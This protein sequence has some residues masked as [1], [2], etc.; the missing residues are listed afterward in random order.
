MNGPSTDNRIAVMKAITSK[1]LAC[2]GL[3]FTLYS[4]AVLAVD[5]DA[6]LIRP[7]VLASMQPG[8]MDQSIADTRTALT[9]HKFSIAGEYSPYKGVHI[10]AVTSDELKSTAA[11]STH[12]GYGAAIR[13]SITQDGAN[14]Q[15][16]YTNPYYMANVYRM[17]SDLEGVTAALKSALG[18]I[19]DFGSEDGWRPKSLRDYHYM[20]FMPY[21]DDHNTLATHSD[22]KTALAAVE[23]GLKAGK[24]GTSKVY[25]IDIPGK[26]ESVFGVALSEG[27]SGDAHIMKI[28]DIANPKHTPHLP[29]ELLVSGNTVYALHGK[30]RIAIDFPDLTMDTFMKISDS[31]D[32]IEKALATAAKGK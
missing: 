13:V 18:R 24:G 4:S 26:E 8:T 28:V 7:Y 21:F 22:H 25:R 9:R 10:I 2:L 32:A 17:S 29:Y 15:V 20:I 6:T 27:E 12:G 31:P 11:K 5:A 1:T 16:A 14:T 19:K 23:A 3:L 30:F